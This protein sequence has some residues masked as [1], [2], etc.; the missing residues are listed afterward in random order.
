[1][2]FFCTKKEMSESM[3]GRK[4]EVFG[5]REISKGIK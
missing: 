5:K 2:N 3:F 1:V 4:Q